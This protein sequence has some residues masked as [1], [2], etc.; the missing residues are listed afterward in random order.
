MIIVSSSRS[1]IFISW[2]GVD[3]L[4]ICSGILYFDN[5]LTCVSVESFQY[6]TFVSLFIVLLLTLLIKMIVIKV[7]L[8]PKILS[9]SIL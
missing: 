5:L 9:I 1:Y 2:I 3:D 6:L 7:I 8:G 4:N